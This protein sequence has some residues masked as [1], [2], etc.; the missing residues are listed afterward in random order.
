VDLFSTK[1][2]SSIMSSLLWI[3]IVVL[4]VIGLIALIA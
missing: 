1:R 2:S 3:V 4:A